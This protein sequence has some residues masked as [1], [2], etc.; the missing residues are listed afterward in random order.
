[1][2][3]QVCSYRIGCKKFDAHLHIL[4]GGGAPYTML[5][6]ILFPSIP[7][8]VDAA[9]QGTRKRK[10]RQPNPQAPPTSPLLTTTKA[11]ELMEDILSLLS[12]MLLV[13]VAS[14]E[15]DMAEVASNCAA[16]ST[17]VECIC[18]AHH[19]IAVSLYNGREKVSA[20][21]LGHS[22]VKEACSY[23]NTKESLFSW[24]G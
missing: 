6:I 7:P 14:L 12:E 22:G 1:M 4:G 21:I 18:M 16:T 8:P 24:L 20:S 3:Q 19:H 23:P 5:Y 13:G 17:C 15:G 2:V 9:K 10:V 11:E